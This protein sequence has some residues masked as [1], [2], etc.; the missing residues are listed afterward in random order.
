MRRRPPRA[1]LTR[2]ATS[3]GTGRRPPLGPASLA[4]A[5]GPRAR[6]ATPLGAGLRGTGL[7]PDTLIYWNLFGGGDGVRMHDTQQ[8]YR[9]RRGPRPLQATTLT[10]GNPY[11]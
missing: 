7:T 3:P 9:H 5:A 4:A 8:R 2:S 1:G 11:Y 6:C 10:W